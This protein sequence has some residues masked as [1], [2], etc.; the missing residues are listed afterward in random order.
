AAK[1]NA[2]DED[3]DGPT[4]YEALYETAVKQGVPRP[5]IE[6]LV[7]IFAYDVD[8]QRKAQQG[9]AFDVLYVKD[10]ENTD[11]DRSGDILYAALT[12]G[13]EVRKFYRYQTKDDGQVDYFDDAGKSA[14]KFLLRK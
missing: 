8:F 11:S 4:L 12:L 2:D 13:D 6:D 7:R 3:D 14:K 10:E 5:M 9:D 1:G